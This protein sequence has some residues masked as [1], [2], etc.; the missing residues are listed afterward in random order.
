MTIIQTYRCTCE[1][2][3][4]Q[5][6]ALRMPSTNTFGSRDSKDVQTESDFYNRELHCFDCGSLE[7][8]LEKITPDE[9]QEQGLRLG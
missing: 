6:G 9:L 8:K 2:C 7:L 5:F 3:G 4:H 1:K